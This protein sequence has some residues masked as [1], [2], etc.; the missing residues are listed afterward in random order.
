MINTKPSFPENQARTT[1]LNSA[2]WTVLKNSC[3]IC[4]GK[5]KNCSQSP[6]ENFITCRDLSATPSGWTLQKVNSIGFGVWVRDS[7][8][9]E[10]RSRKTREEYAKVK[11]QQEQEE[12][13]IEALRVKALL[14]PEEADLEIKKLLTQLSLL[15][16]DRQ[17][18]EAK[19]LSDR[20]IEKGG[21]R[22]LSQRWQKLDNP[23]NDRLPG[24][25]KGGQQLNNP[26]PCILCPVRDAN[27]RYSALR[28][29]HSRHKE[30]EVGKYVYLSSS[31]R[32]ISSK[33]KNGELPIAVQIPENRSDL[34][35]IGI[36]EGFEIKSFLAAERLGIPTIGFGNHNFSAS[37]KATIEALAQLS[38]EFTEPPIITIY[39]DAGAV[40]NKAVYRDYL[41]A[42][43]LYSSW[44]YEVEFAWWEQIDKSAGDIDEIDLATTA[45]E[46]ISP[47]AFEQ[48]GD[49]FQQDRKSFYEEL[50]AQFKG[51]NKRLKR[52]FNRYFKKGKTPPKKLIYRGN[53]ALPSPDDYLGQEPPKIIFK[54]GDRH[55][56]L[57]DLLEAGWNKVLDRSFMGLGKSHDMGTLANSE[58]KT[59]YLDLNHRNPSVATIE[60]NFEDLPVRHGGLVEDPLRVTPSGTPY[61]K[62]AQPGETPDTAALC[63]NAHLFT[64][65]YGKGYQVDGFSDESEEGSKL[66]PICA[67]CRFVGACASSTGNGYGFR[68][69][70]KEA[71]NHQRIRASIN[72]LPSSEDYSYERDI[73]VIEEASQI[74]KHSKSISAD[75]GDIALELF[76]F[77]RFPLLYKI[78]SP[79]LR[80]ITPYLEGQ[81][82]LTRYGL[83]HKDII[84]ILG[85]P[86]E[87]IEEAIEVVAAENPL[88]KGLIAQAEKVSGWGKDWQNSQATANWYLSQEA[89]RITE[90]NI[91]N[92]PSNFLIN[93]LLVWAGIVPGALRVNN[94]RKLSVTIAH[95]RHA[96]ILKQMKAVVM[97]DA[98]GDKN[99]LGRC[100]NVEANSIIEIEQELPPMANLSVV[101]VHMEGMASNNLSSSCIG[102]I[103]KLTSHLKSQHEDIPILGLKKYA[104]EIELDGYWFADHRGSNAFKGKEA[105]AAFGK[106]MI[107]I[108]VAEDEYLT[109][110]GSLDGFE[111]YYQRLIDADI[112]Q[113]I[114][115]PR[116]HLFPDRQFTI[117]LIGDHQLEHLEKYGINVA[118]CEAF[119]I[120]AEAGSAKQV[121]QRKMIEAV[122]NLWNNGEKI[123]MKIIA[124]QT[125]LSACYIKKLARGLGGMVALKKWV[126]SLYDSYRSCT[127][128]FD[129]DFL[130]QQQKIKRWIGLN[131]AEAVRDAIEAIEA[132]GWRDFQLYLDDFSVGVQARMWS[133]LLPMIFSDDE[134]AQLQ[135]EIFAPPE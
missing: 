85:N 87:D 23:L 35:K 49:E 99:H 16:S 126:L 51:A 13:R 22:S 7:A 28:Q 132:V 58:G 31:G 84:S 118:Q 86:P 120:T 93:L 133:L 90:E 10:Q 82:K 32:G 45:I 65:L 68:F 116:A 76:R 101:N 112:V 2:R 107:N 33:D 74:I 44:G 110:Y 40:K 11:K 34:N 12:A 38:E 125:G 111:A 122:A 17:I 71:L 15:K 73:A 96:E 92:L 5:K 54:K 104:E 117:Y 41:R 30:L 128:K 103:E 46:Y 56:L 121:S 21:Y 24:L 77:E 113:F 129:L 75:L 20:Q 43:K 36:C 102:R 14:S 131:P 83:S 64:Q 55:R 69:A 48:I 18:L 50:I 134:I 60:S 97:L 37:P 9:N 119:E 124:S 26:H 53:V 94:F 57:A 114:G 123:N 4:Q 89:Q 3:P 47:A 105:I 19:G 1:V 106:P 62:W 70:R 78:L 81:Q 63:E 25:R 80:K 100:L 59:W 67:S 79:A 130:L 61:Q 8:H 135:T 29:Y 42:S 66:N 109:L 88:I 98:T 52:G 91:S 95:D 127:Q 115:R 72:S 108:G 6:D 27:G 39:G